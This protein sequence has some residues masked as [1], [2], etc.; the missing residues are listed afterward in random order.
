MDNN[1]TARKALLFATLGISP[2]EIAAMAGGERELGEVMSDRIRE[3]IA[4]E[5][6]TTKCAIVCQNIKR[7]GPS[8]DTLDPEIYLKLIDELRA[9]GGRFATDSSSRPVRVLSASGTVNTVSSDTITHPNGETYEPEDDSQARPEGCVLLG[10]ICPHPFARLIA[11]C[12]DLSLCGVVIFAMMRFLIRVNPTIDPYKG[13]STEAYVAVI[14]TY[15]FMLI[16]E[17]FCLNIFGTTP[18]KFILGIRVTAI[19][20][21]KLSLKDGYI[22]CL[23]LMIYGLGLMLPIISI[24]AMIS[25]CM[26]CSRQE[27]LLWDMGIRLDY[28]ES[29]PARRTCIGLAVLVLISLIDTLTNTA[30]SIPSNRGN[31]TEEQ[32]YENCAEIYHY[33]SL[34]IDSGYSYQLTTRNGYVT[35]VTFEITETEAS[36]IPS[37]Y[38]PIYVA[39]YA[40]AG[41]RRNVGAFGLTFGE[42]QVILNSLSRDFDLTI[43]DLHFTN[44]IET[45]GYVRNVLQGYYYSDGTADRCYHQT[46]TISLE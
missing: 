32:F 6:D 45:Q 16:L 18:G 43:A 24:I 37:Y 41:S 8:Y 7:D 11:R 30:A 39:L 25:S 26:K 20:G 2:A 29:S 10:T 28:T 4:D 42:G 14:S 36:Q 17:P 12:I 5:T 1:I 21:S 13:L 3:S 27:L 19:D 33:N 46:F 31:I 22:R 9:G 40:F 38:D 34:A 15:L 23:K 35:G 44:V